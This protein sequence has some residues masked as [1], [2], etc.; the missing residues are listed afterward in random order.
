MSLEI[1]GYGGKLYMSETDF[2]KLL[3]LAEEYGWEAMGTEPYREDDDEWPGYYAGE[4]TVVYEDSLT[5]ADALDRALPHIPKLGQKFEGPTDS[6]GTDA[7]PDDEPAKHAVARTWPASDYRLPPAPYFAGYNGQDFV[8]HF[9]AY[10]R[11][12]RFHIY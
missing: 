2:N 11:A 3:D 4:S 6:D 7:K 1:M 8:R 5:L 10:C 12:G 9:I